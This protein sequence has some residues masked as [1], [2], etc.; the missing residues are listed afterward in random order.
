MRHFSNT[1]PHR[2]MSFLSSLETISQ[3]CAGAQARVRCLRHIQRLYTH[4]ANGRGRRWVCLAVSGWLVIPVACNSPLKVRRDAGQ[5]TDAG[6]G[7]AS[8]DNLLPSM[9]ARTPS[10]LAPADGLPAP[11]AELP[12]HTYK[13]A[14]INTAPDASARSWNWP[15]QPHDANATYD[16]IFSDDGAQVHIVRTDPVQ[17]ETMDGV[18]SEQSESQLVYAIDNHW[19]GAELAVRIDNDTLVAQLAVF[20][21][22]LPVVSCIESTMVSG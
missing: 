7:G 2:T 4:A 6:A 3:K 18:L 19:A 15:C 5:S 16:L 14:A 12:G 9:D 1:F 20:G 10:D 11:F 22:G 8:P 21:S 17:E 13:I